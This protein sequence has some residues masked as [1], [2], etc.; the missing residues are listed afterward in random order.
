M[1]FK[2]WEKVYW[3]IIGFLFALSCLPLFGLGEGKV[4]GKK[5]GEGGSKGAY[6]G[7]LMLYLVV[8]P[9]ILWIIIRL[10]VNKDERTKKTN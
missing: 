3:V 1:T 4:D 8:I 9:A 5:L 2:T 10:I 7:Y 6:F